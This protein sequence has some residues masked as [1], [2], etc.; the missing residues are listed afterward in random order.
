MTFSDVFKNSFMENFQSTGVDMNQMLV[1][2]SFTAVMAIFVFVIYRVVTR[3]EFYSKSFNISLV[4]MAIITAS[5]ILA[6]QSSVVISLGMV[7]ALS[8]VRFRTAIKSPMDL[9]FLYWA[10]GIGI[11]CGAGLYK[12]AIVLSLVLAAC[13]FILEMIP[14]KNA[15]LVVVINA[16]KC[17]CE[18]ILVNITSK[19]CKSYNIK[20]RNMTI[21]T[22]DMVL[23]VRCEKQKELIL[24]LANIEGVQHVAILSHDGEVVS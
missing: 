16:N 17:D 11:I 7:G 5:I 23:E 10:I 13:L 21:D 24:E 2:L 15:P 20:S 19:Y 6:I 1:A 8:I 9:V 4:A 12:V 14:V 3:K 22:F 18:D